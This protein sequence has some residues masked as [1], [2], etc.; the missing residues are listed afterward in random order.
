MTM[1]EKKL[2]IGC[3]FILCAGKHDFDKRNNKLQ[4]LY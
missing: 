4:L 1:F 2:E 3:G